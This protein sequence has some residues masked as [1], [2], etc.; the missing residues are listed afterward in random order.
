[1]GSRLLVGLTV[2]RPDGGGKRDAEA[3]RW[4]VLTVREGRIVDIV[5]FDDRNEA[6]A[7][8]AVPLS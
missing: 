7:R 6:V 4:Q 8:A 2:M 3:A 5:G 1:M